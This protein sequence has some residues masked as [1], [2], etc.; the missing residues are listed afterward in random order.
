MIQQLTAR[1]IGFYLNLLAWFSPRRAGDAG[2]YLFCSPRRLSLQPHQREFLDAADSFE[3]VSNGNTL[4]GY[5]WGRGPR[6]ILFVHGWQSHS[7]RWKNYIKAF[8]LDQYTIYAFDAPAHGQSGGRYLN[9][10]IY[11]EAIEE[12]FRRFG[13]VYAVVSHSLGSFAML[14]S[15]YRM[16]RLPVERLVVTGIPGEVDEFV[17]YFRQVLGLSSHTMDAIS[18][19]FLRKINALPSDFSAPQFAAG[20]TLPGLIIH[21]EYDKETPYVH[22]VAVHRAWPGSNL[23]TTHGLGHNL[24]SA[25]V[26][27]RITSFLHQEETGSFT[28]STAVESSI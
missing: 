12:F 23:V 4:R 18:R 14:F 17:N 9:L 25:D 10:V 28:R 26:V 2:F 6:R 11:S 8:P 16:G 20:M 19:A 3:F 24:R 7:F 15:H 22:A 13:P 1:T 27:N 21:D 5:R